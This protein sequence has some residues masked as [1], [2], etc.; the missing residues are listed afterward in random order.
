MKWTMLAIHHDRDVSYL[1]EEV[2]EEQHQEE[3]EGKGEDEGEEPVVRI[4]CLLGS[5]IQ[6]HLLQSAMYVNKK[7]FI[8]HLV[9]ETAKEVDE[10]GEKWPV[11]DNKVDADEDKEE[12]PDD[13][14]DDE[15]EHEEEGLPPGVLLSIG[16]RRL[17]NHP[18]IKGGPSCF[19]P[20]CSQRLKK[21]HNR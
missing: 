14:E 5:R 9:D 18:G 20:D 4:F 3:V 2:G 10:D 17:P 16:H 13:D 6:F 15:E 11:V 21:I 8:F 1:I 7:I 19:L 12:E